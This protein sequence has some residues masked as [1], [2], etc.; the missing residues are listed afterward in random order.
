MPLKPKVEY[1]IDL[2]CSLC[3]KNPKFSDVSHLL[4]HIASKG[5]LSHRF[6]LQIRS[7]GE[8]EAKQTLDHFDFWYRTS[9]IDALLSERLAAK[10]NKK[11]KK[12]RASSSNPSVSFNA[13]T[14][15]SYL[16]DPISQPSTDS[17]SIDQAGERARTSTNDIR[18]R[19]SY[20]SGTSSCHAALVR[21]RSSQQNSFYNY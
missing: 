8:P 10:D 3:P 1:N 21:S 9:N 12:S 16:I 13:T 5:H 15:T 19:G 14:S 17:C 7:Q 4:T 11:A 20:V 18:T 6:K 2:Q